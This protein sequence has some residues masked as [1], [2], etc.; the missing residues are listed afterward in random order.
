MVGRVPDVAALAEDDSLGTGAVDALR[1]VNVL[2]VIT[3]RFLRQLA[4]A[5]AERRAVVAMRVPLTARDPVER[6]LQ[7]DRPFE[8]DTTEVTNRL[9]FKLSR[10]RRRLLDRVC[11]RRVSSRIVRRLS[12]Q[13]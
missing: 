6:R 9:I 7:V 2:G 5:I 13:L 11:F 8:N 10:R 12:R 4:F 1:R 3:L